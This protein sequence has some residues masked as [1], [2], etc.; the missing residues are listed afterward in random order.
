MGRTIPPEDVFTG[1]PYARAELVRRRV[2]LRETVAAFEASGGRYHQLAQANLVRW[3]KSAQPITR[4]FEVLAGDWGD[5]TARQ[6]RAYGVCFA[7]LNMANAYVP[8]G[9]YVEGTVAQE[10]N[11]FRR[12]DCHFAVDATQYDRQADRYLPHMSALLNAQQGRVLLDTQKPRVCIR[13]PEDRTQ[14]DLGYSWLP[15]DEVFP[16]YELRAAAVDLRG[17]GTFDPAETYRRVIAQLDTLRAA[18]VRHAILSAF[19]CGAFLNPAQQV[20]KAYAQAL[21]EREQDF[22]RVAF[23]IFHAGYGPDNFTPFAQVFASVFG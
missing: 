23:A 16:F 6:T 17:G 13:G 10:E 1:T 3:S 19:G 7:V 14:A 20:A 8:G 12:T 22:D 4:K 15:A 9:S 2:V 5:V 18:N 21:Q 11:M